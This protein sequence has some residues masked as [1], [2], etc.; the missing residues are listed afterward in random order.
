MVDVAVDWKVPAELGR[1]ML[2]SKM[3][4]VVGEERERVIGMFQSSLTICTVR[5]SN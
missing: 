5:S 2:G 3:G 4:V 1:N